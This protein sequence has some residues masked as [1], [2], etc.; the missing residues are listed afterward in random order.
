MKREKG[1]WKF[2]AAFIAADRKPCNFSSEWHVQEA[3]EP[4]A[5]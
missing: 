2:R 4:S 3:N 1:E 5:S